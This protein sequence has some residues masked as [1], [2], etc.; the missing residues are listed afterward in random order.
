VITGHLALAYGA[1]GA[2]RDRRMLWLAGATVA[3][4]VVDL[5]L[6]LLQRCSP[7]GLYS[8]SIPALAVLAP[9]AAAVCWIAT[10][11]RR[12][13]AAALA[14]SVLHLPLDLVTGRKVVWPYQALFGLDVYK[15][16]VLDLAIELPMLLIGWW[17]A[18][19]VLGASGFWRSRWLLGALVALQCVL[20]VSKISK[21]DGQLTSQNDSCRAAYRATIR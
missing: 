10:R 6:A 11:D 16:P 14:I 19:S 1:S 21:K 17:Y 7:Y 18:R 15:V 8:H 5:G 20:A 13:T 2:L 3:S 4:D 9:A 12:V